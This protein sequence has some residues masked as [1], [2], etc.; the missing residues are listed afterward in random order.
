MEKPRV[1]EICIE[2]FVEKIHNK[3]QTCATES[4]LNYKKTKKTCVTESALN[5][6]L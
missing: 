6:E 5:S 2:Y 3:Q 1:E 4:A